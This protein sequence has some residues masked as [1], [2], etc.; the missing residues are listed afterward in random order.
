MPERLSEVFRRRLQ[1]IL[2]LS[3]PVLLVT[4]FA[5][6]SLGAAIWKP[7]TKPLSRAQSF[8]AMEILAT[9]YSHLAEERGLAFSAMKQGVSLDAADI[10]S[11][12]SRRRRSKSLLDQFEDQV[13]SGALRLPPT[14]IFFSSLVYNREDVDRLRQQV[15]HWGPDEGHSEFEELPQHWFN[16]ASRLLV[17]IASMHSELHARLRLNDL[18]ADASTAMQLQYLALLMNDYAGRERAIVSGIIGSNASYAEIER[19]ELKP[20][21]RR[22]DT[23]WESIRQLA[24]GENV[25]P[26]LKQMIVQIEKAFFIELKGTRVALKQANLAG[27]PYPVTAKE[28]FSKS[29]RAIETIVELSKQTGELSHRIARNNVGE[30]WQR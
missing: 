24:K 2:R 15:D 13:N 20:Y 10:Q 5:G 9:A 17:S 27:K 29:T 30:N 1:R 22:I 19:R 18:E 14:N 7:A 8:R 3:V 26:K 16:G 4:F 11:L 12:I 28:W 23:I 21:R 6:F 25:E